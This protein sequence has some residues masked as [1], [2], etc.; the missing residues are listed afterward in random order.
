LV[1]LLF[2]KAN[3]NTN[4]N[5][6]RSN[7]KYLLCSVKCIGVAVCLAAYASTKVYAFDSN[8]IE[9]RQA[10]Q[11]A[12]LLK[13]ASREVNVNINTDNKGITE[14]GAVTN[15]NTDYGDVLSG[16]DASMVEINE[17]NINESRVFDPEKPDNYNIPDI[18]PS[19]FVVPL[20]LETPCFKINTLR[21]QGAQRFSWLPIQARTVAGH[22]VG[23]NTVRKLQDHLN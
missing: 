12:K 16:I 9:R 23:V 20:V 7:S 6:K 21:F 8:S 4:M 19:A 17:N 22:C 18:N 10:E 5:M 15:I 1:K 13:N 2:K 14:K 11:Q 3:M